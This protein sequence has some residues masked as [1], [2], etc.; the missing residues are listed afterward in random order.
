M[1]YITLIHYFVFASDKK[2]N[3]C[4][5]KKLKQREK[6]MTLYIYLTEQKNDRNIFRFKTYAA[7]DIKL[8]VMLV[9]ATRLT[10]D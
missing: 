4:A 7:I 1:L 8:Q 6:C 9:V 2:R 10:L 3:I 5:R